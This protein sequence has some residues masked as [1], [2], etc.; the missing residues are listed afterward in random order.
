MLIDVEVPDEIIEDR[1]V[2][3]NSVR[4]GAIIADVYHDELSRVVVFRIE[5]TGEQCYNVEN[6]VVI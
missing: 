4:G 1:I 3:K 2:S 5:I 6:T